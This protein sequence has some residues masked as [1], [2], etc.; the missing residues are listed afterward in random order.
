MAMLNNQRVNQNISPSKSPF[1]IP[2]FPARDSTDGDAFRRRP[3]F[4]VFVFPEAPRV[5]GPT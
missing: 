5:H 2:R 1:R 3:A 4:K